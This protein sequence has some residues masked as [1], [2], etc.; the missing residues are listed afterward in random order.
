MI[1][2]NPKKIGSKL[3]DGR[4][5]E[6]FAW[7]DDLILKLYREGWSRR[8]AEYEHRMAKA[9]ERT[10][11]RVPHV[12]EIIEVDG[13]PGIIY[14]RVEGEPM[15]NQIRKQPYRLFHFSHQMADLHLEMHTK[16]AQDLEPVTE[17]LASKIDA[18][19]ALDHASK[20]F[21]FE[22]K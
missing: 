9:S 4:T 20:Q 6:V 21:I 2:S 1:R 10:G 7:G 3:A 12:G 15:F 5:A 11:Y 18:V 14:Q 13:R 8:T 16:D 22:R 19:N 17:R